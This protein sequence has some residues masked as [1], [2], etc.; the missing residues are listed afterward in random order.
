LTESQGKWSD[1]HLEDASVLRPSTRGRILEEG[2]KLACVGGLCRV[3]F[4]A[5]A[6]R[7]NVSKSGVVAHFSNIDKLKAGVIARATDLWR[8][9]CCVP[10]EN[11]SGATELTRYMSRWISWTTRAGLPVG[12]PIAAAMFEYAHEGSSVRLAVET[13][14][15]QWRETLVDLIEEAITGSEVS[16]NIDA[17]QMACSLFGVYLAHQVSSRF[18][19]APDA[20]RKAI[21]T[22]DQLIAFA[23]RPSEYPKL[24][25]WP[26]RASSQP[27]FP[28]LAVSAALDGRALLPVR[29]FNESMTDAA[30][31]HNSSQIPQYR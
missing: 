17:S 26:Q 1:L 14:E 18:L 16:Q 2:L 19:R 28:I 4:G 15:A 7:A 23:K 27:V 6:Q 10:R 25:R 3:T 24:T 12:C 22:V 29:R 30:Y 11:S 13:A 21:E 31:S 20:D 8:L 9:A 5:L